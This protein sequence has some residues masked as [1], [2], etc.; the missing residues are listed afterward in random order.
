MRTSLDQL[1]LW[2]P[3][4][5]GIAVALF[6]GVFA[7]DAFRPGQSFG[8][9][10]LGF[11][12]HLIPAAVLLV[13]VLA[14]W[15]RPWIGAIVFVSIALFYAARVPGGRLDW[16]LVIS[17]PLMVVGLLFLGSWR[18]PSAGSPH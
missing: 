4:I 8:S 18:H 7:L 1:V 9:G 10:L 5:L 12:V 17:G 15:R 2:A 11:A 13:T 6:V 14:A 3:R 16:I